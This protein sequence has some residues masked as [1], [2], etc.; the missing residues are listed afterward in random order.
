MQ[1]SCAFA[2]KILLIHARLLFAEPNM[3]QLLSERQ[4]NSFTFCVNI[5]IA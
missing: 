4:Q 5:Q 3:L 1:Q 2:A